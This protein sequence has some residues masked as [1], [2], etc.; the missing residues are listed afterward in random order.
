[1]NFAMRKNLVL[2][3]SSLLFATTSFSQLTVTNLLTEN[4]INPIGI[5]AVQPRFSWQ[6][7]SDKRNTMQT[8]YEIKIT[9]GK[10]NIW[11]SGK[12]NDDSS[13]HVVYKGSPLE[14]N[15]KY[16]WQVRVWDNNNEASKWS[17]PAFFQTALFNTSDWKAKWIEPG[18]AED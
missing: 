14:S 8:A 1:M 5:D 7:N 18:Y 16:T 4:R 3:L 9:S 15:T 17:E 10:K 13:V 2:F 6:L 11:S 12:V